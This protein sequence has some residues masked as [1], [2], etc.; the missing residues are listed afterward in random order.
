MTRKIIIRRHKHVQ[1]TLDN[2]QLQIKA[3]RK[4][5]NIELDL[6]ETRKERTLI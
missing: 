2:E 4:G 1:H 5:K 3:I 6:Y